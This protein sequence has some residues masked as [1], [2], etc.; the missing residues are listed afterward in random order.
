MRLPRKHA[1]DLADLLPCQL[2]AVVQRNVESIDNQLLQLAIVLH[3]QA[4]EGLA[5]KAEARRL[6]ANAENDKLGNR[7]FN[8]MVALDLV[9]G[10]LQAGAGGGKGQGSLVGH[11][12]G[13]VSDK[14]HVSALR[15]TR[16]ADPIVDLGASISV[17]VDIQVDQQRKWRFSSFR[18]GVSGVPMNQKSRS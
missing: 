8:L 11:Y 12:E 16:I 9:M 1:I 6:C 13:E 4:I 10:D 3:R 15:L 17:V 2:A 7:L 18:Q 5:V 14:H